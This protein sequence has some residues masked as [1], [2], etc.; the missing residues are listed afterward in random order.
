MGGEFNNRI[1]IIGYGAVARCMLPILLE[2][3]VIPG[4]RITVLD[5]LDKSAELA[6]Y[7]A[8]GIRFCRVTISPENLDEILSAHVSAGDLVIDVAW[9][10]DCCDIVRWCH[11]RGV[12][13]V[14]TSIEVW[15]A[16]SEQVAADLLEKSLYYRQ[17]KLRDLTT[18]WHEG[19]T[20]VVDHGANPGLISHFAKQGICDIARRMIADG[21]APDP[22]LLMR[23]L[24]ERNFGRLA[25]ETG[26][27][28]IH[29][30][31][32]DTQV[33]C[34]PKQ[35]GEFV[36]TW[37]IEGM[38]DEGIAP[39]ELGWGT[40]EKEL[41]QQAHLPQFGP[42]NE[43]IIA[44]PGINT[45]VRS[46][47]PGQEIVG[48]LIQHSEAFGISDLLTVTEN[49]KV[50][51]RP[52]VNY[53]YLPCDA[54][55]ASLHELRCRNY[56]LQQTFRIMDDSEIVSGADILGALL[57]GHPYCSW[58]T[59]SILS[60]GD[61]RR[62]APG[63]NATTVQVAI[64]LVSA[65]VWMIENPKEGFCI[66]DDLPHEYI[67]EIAAPYLGEFRSGPSDWT[68]LKDRTVLFRENP[69]NTFDHNDVWQFRNFLFV[70]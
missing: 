69:N 64:G 8:Q 27:R 23:L 9:N 30:S 61:A 28:V 52:T 14:N 55:I 17:M 22:D 35:E 54:T 41:P 6:H 31:E 32:R 60:I 36:G 3:I 67:L 39:A 38:L 62:F 2:H 57:M 44:R 56:E 20:C 48:M 18:D 66:P 10:I 53:A 11:D 13:Y 65:V 50:V 46:W 24:R 12:L 70:H 37:C 47:V 45:W 68:P 1:L 33:S 7:T 19:P 4:D 25:M 26:I 5:A 58:W 59:G 34:S 21:I 63:Q 29:C 51:Y 16:K 42:K 49:G 40:H 15:D 43:I